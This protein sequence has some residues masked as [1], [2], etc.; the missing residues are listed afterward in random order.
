MQSG[1]LGLEGKV[2]SM[3]G[4]GSSGPGAGTG[5]AI[6]ILFSLSTRFHLT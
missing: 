3:T 5:K 1:R 2:A 4:V 6:S